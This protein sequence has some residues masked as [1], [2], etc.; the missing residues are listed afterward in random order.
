MP[1]R[2][3]GLLGG[4]VVDVGGV[5][6]GARAPEQAR[7]VLFSSGQAASHRRCSW[8]WCFKGSACA[9]HS[10]QSMASV[11]CHVAPTSHFWVVCS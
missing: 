11:F 3:P 2:E 8:S 7:G 9:A 1:G 5:V 4:G 10:V 6:V